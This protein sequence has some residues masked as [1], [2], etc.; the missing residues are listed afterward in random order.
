SMS[1]F[2]P[3]E[4]LSMMRELQHAAVDDVAGDRNHVGTQ[5]I[6][7]IDDGLHEIPFDGGADVDVTDLGDG[8]ALELWR[9]IGQRYFHVDH[10]G[11]AARYE[12]CEAVAWPRRVWRLIQLSLPVSSSR[13]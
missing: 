12:E 9:K 3:C 5:A 4:R 11:D 1:R 6:H 10:R 8:E 13:R 2:E 7:P